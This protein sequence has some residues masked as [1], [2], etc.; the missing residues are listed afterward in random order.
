M[1]SI[2][3]PALRRKTE[4]VT[5]AASNAFNIVEKIA[6]V[7][8]PDELADH[9]AD[10]AMMR[11]L[12]RGDQAAME[13]LI[14]VHGLA[15]QR[16]VGRLTGWC[17][18]Q[19]DILQDVLL[20]I[21]QRAG[22]FHGSGSLGGWIRMIAVNR[23]RNYFRGRDTVRRL[24]AVFT[25]RTVIRDSAENE[26]LSLI[27]SSEFTRS[28]LQR[29]NAQDRSVLVLFY[30]EELSGDEIASMTNVRVDTVH[31]QLHRARKR[32]RAILE[33]DS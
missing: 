11:E 20:T 6:A 26:D 27:E 31:V 7:N 23:C 30:L 16:L 17:D 13:A 5:V 14:E 29:L 9:G 21:W 28:A 1:S 32:L 10:V 33:D 3:K 25:N 8:E 15:L 12:A 2:T 18:E 4:S 22:S 19:E 24:L